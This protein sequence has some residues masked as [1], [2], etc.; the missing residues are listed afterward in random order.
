M[1]THARLSEPG[2][3]V[4]S[5]PVG[6]KNKGTNEEWGEEFTGTRTTNGGA[7]VVPSFCSPY[8]TDT[9][10]P[11]LTTYKI[12][13]TYFIIFCG[14]RHMRTAEGIRMRENE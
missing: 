5:P 2:Q 1:T 11:S 13:C 8:V 10:P 9:L 3:G 12:S 14:D 4:L 6:T 7:A